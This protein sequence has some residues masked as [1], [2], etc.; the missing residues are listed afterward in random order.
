MNLCVLVCFQLLAFD[1][2]QANNEAALLH[3]LRSDEE[4][5]RTLVVLLS[6]T[7]GL[8]LSFA[9]GIAIQH[10]STP[11]HQYNDEEDDIMQVP[12]QPLASSSP[13]Q[14]PASIPNASEAHVANPDDEDEAYHSSISK[15]PA[16]PS[17][18]PP[19][20]PV[21]AMESAREAVPPSAPSAKELI[22]SSSLCMESNEASSSSSSS[23]CP[24]C[25]S[26][27]F[28]VS[29]ALMTAVEPPPPAYQQ[30]DARRCGEDRPSLSRNPDTEAAMSFVANQPVYSNQN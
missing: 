29:R 2:V 5:L 17:L 25:P 14:P 24:H 8:A 28:M 13:V 9:L 20:P 7:G 1:V 12:V 18:P 10:H 15:T 11:S 19:P 4:H 23:C 30:V 16:T 21:P 22:A 3:K 27:P 26:P 6:L